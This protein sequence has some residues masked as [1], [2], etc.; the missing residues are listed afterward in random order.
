MGEG[1]F[2]SL[3]G[4]L[5]RHAPDAMTRRIAHLTRQDE[6]RHVA[7]ALSHLERHAGSEPDL[8]SRLARAVEQRHHAL[9]STSGLKGEV[10]DALVLLAAGAADPQSISTGWRRVQQLQGEMAESPA[11]R[12]ARLGFTPGEAETLSSLHT[13][14]FM[15]HVGDDYECLGK[16]D[17]FW[18][19]HRAQ[20]VCG[21]QFSTLVV[22][23]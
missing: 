10:F 1:T 8:R 16:G 22:A 12:L 5:E 15:W 3:L 18:P 11:A 19:V 14:N 21:G 20:L 7:F 17:S 23:N 13:R 6:A 4:F 2:V 9:Q